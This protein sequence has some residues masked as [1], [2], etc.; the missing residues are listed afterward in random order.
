MLFTK[1]TPPSTV[2]PSV[3]VLFPERVSGPVTVRLPSPLIAPAALPSCTVR[4]T[5]M[6]SS[7]ELG[8]LPKITVV[9]PLS[10][11]ILLEKPFMYSVPLAAVPISPVPPNVAVPVSNWPVMIV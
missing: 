9:P 7:Y 1:S 5:G 2:V 8:A 10:V 11:V 6:G 4:S 3:Y